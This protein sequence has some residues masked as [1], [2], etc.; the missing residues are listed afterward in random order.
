MQGWISIPT[1]P[2]GQSKADPKRA[3]M[4]RSFFCKSW[5][6]PVDRDR[7]WCDEGDVDCLFME[8]DR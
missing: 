4:W 1:S 3:P 5:S 6:K 7:A 8:I 2:Q